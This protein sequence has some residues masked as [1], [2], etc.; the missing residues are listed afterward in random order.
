MRRFLVPSDDK[1]VKISE[2]KKQR[3]HEEKEDDPDEHNIP[4]IPK[5]SIESFESKSY[6]L[7]GQFFSIVKE[8][9]TKLT[10]QCKNCSKIIQGQKL[11]T[12]NF[13]SHIKV[14]NYKLFVILL[15][16]TYTFIISIL[17]TLSIPIK[18]KSIFVKI[19]ST[20]INHCFQKLKRLEKMQKNL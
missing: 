7:D 14:I 18:Q 15:H 6:L 11:S 17:N 20:S 19:F 12:G 13:L 4:N 1:N 10:A 8:D 16:S 2:Y 5:V 9:G 3:L